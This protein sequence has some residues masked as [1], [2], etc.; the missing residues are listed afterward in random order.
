MRMYKFGK[1]TNYGLWTNKVSDRFMGCF[2]APKIL[3]E[4]VYII[5]NNQR[6]FLMTFS[7]YSF[8]IFYGLL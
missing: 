8:Q 3:V 5:L 1:D 4:D 2:D 6:N 7:L